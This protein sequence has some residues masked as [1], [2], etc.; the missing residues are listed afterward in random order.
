[1]SDI[2][3]YISS[4]NN[5]DMLLH[6]IIPNIRFDAKFINIDDNSCEKEINKGKD[7]CNKH[8]IDFIKN[9]G[10]GLFMAAKTVIN[11]VMNDNK[12]IKYV[13]WLTHDCLP[14]DNKMFERLDNIVSSGQLDDFGCVGFN[15]IWRKFSFSKSDFLSKNLSGKYCGT[16]GRA[17]LTP[18]PGAGW[19]RSSDFEM[20][21]SVWGKNIAVESVVD[22]NFMI[23]TN[24]FLKHIVPDDKFKH[25]CWGDDLCLQFLRNNCYNITLADYYVYHDQSL[26]AKYNI[27]ENSYSGAK[28]GD[29]Y[30]FCSHDAH[31]G[32]WKEKWGFDRDWQKKMDRL[33]NDISNR[34]H[35]L[36]LHDFIT[37]NYKNGPLKSFEIK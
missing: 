35:N 12:N 9:D 33:P 37:H 7:I 20:D 16:M 31:Y 18:V 36:I 1:M 5:Y 15:T 3:I 2:A 8:G 13:Y 19:Y 34:Y 32:R 28:S 6:E 22:M 24:L 26:K 11:R 27:P 29:Q 14:L 30:H 21:W 4:K 23:N 10:S 25:F 17:V